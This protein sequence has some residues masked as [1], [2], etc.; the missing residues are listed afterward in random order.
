MYLNLNQYY[1]G[2]IGPVTKKYKETLLALQYQEIDDP[3][4]WLHKVI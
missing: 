4:G 2:E 3:F 1:N